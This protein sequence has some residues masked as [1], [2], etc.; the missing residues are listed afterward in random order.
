MKTKICIT[1][2]YL[3]TVLGCR[4]QAPSFKEDKLLSID[5]LYKEKTYRDF[6]TIDFKNI[7]NVY[8]LVIYRQGLKKIPKKVYSLS[9]LNILEITYNEL[10]SIPAKISELRYLQDL[11]FQHNK[12]KEFPRVCFQIEHLKRLDLSYNKIDKIP[13][14]I[15]RIKTL[16][17]LYL[18]SNNIN[19]IPNS[20]FSLNSLKVL[21]LDNNN[22]SY[23]SD[24]LTKMP[25]LKKLFINNNSLSKIPPVHKC[26]NFILLEIG[27]NNIPRDSLKTYAKKYPHIMIKF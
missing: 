23:L 19:S 22:I 2:V 13:Q 4:Q 25:N 17:E 21:K 3:L 1:I 16:E 5:R 12:I 14:D 18:A 15:Y 8:K 24:S 7:D 11:Y 20:L 6:H 26:S 27:N 9:Y 10:C